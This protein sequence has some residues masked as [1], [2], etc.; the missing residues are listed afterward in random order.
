M[1]SKKLEKTINEQINEELFSAYI[2]L[3]MSAWFETQNLKGFANWMYIQYQEE[4]THA[5]KFF[6]YI[7]ERGG[8]V[9]LEA[10][11]KPETDW[12][13]PFLA[14]EE[15]LKHEKHITSKINNLVTIAR[16]EKDYATESFL[17]WYVDEQV[18]EE[19]NAME[20]LAQLKMIGESK[21]GLLMLDKELS[22][23]VFVDATKKAE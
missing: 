1:L 18:E 2:Y 16:V 8:Q 20:I 6:R 5:M 22:T 15:T 12:K 11:Q 7:N 10:V 3:S 14:F 17:A 9:I 23:R 4:V 21:T 13:N 19:A